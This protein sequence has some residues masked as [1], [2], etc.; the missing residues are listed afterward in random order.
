MF[1]LYFLLSS[2]WTRFLPTSDSCGSSLKVF[3]LVVQM[4]SSCCQSGYGGVD[5]IKP[6]ETV[7]FPA[8]ASDRLQGKDGGSGCGEPQ[9]FCW[10]MIQH[11][12]NSSSDP[13]GQATEPLDPPHLFLVILRMLDV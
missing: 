6:S 8:A 7:R 5:I 11:G 3:S 1:W 12:G 2:P 13:G 4:V 9:T 10:Q